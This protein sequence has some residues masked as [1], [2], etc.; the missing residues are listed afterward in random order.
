MIPNNKDLEEFD[1]KFETV[2]STKHSEFIRIP[3]GI[4]GNMIKFIQ[5]RFVSKREL[6]KKL[7]SMKRNNSNRIGLRDYMEIIADGN[8]NEALADV[9]KFIE[10]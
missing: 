7:E 1:K 10:G 3:D 8:Y 2:W 6:M 4:K 9:I 5:Q